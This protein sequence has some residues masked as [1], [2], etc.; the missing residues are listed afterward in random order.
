ML[1]QSESVG[2]LYCTAINVTGEPPSPKAGHLTLILS[3]APTAVIVGATGACGFL[4]VAEVTIAEYVV[5]IEFVAHRRTSYTVSSASDVRLRALSV[6]ASVTSRHVLVPVTRYC[7]TSPVTVSPPSATAGHVT[8][9]LPMPPTA[10]TT[11][12]IGAVLR[13][14]G[15]PRTT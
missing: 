1:T 7:N 5:P 14:A 11:P 13:A 2:R 12:T 8:D 4:S 9:M 6:T 3:V 10:V 15:T